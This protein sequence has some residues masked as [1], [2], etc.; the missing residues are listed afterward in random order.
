MIKNQHDVVI[1][2]GANIDS[3]WRAHHKIY[4]GSSS[5]GEKSEYFG[6]VARNIAEALAR[7]GILCR[8]VSRVGNDEHGRA[9]VSHLQALSVDTE[10][11]SYS[12]R[13]PTAN[14]CAFFHPS[15]DVHTALVDLRIYDECCDEYFRACIPQCGTSKVAVLDTD[16]PKTALSF[17]A[18]SLSQEL[19]VSV[20]CVPAVVKLIPM[21]HHIDVLFLN[22]RELSLLCP[23]E[24][25]FCDQ[26]AWLHK[27][28]VGV[29]VVTK[30]EEGA[31]LLQHGKH[32]HVPAI[33][34][35]VIDVTGAGDA[36]MA[37]CLA[38]YLHGLPLA[39]SLA[40]GMKA[41]SLTLETKYSVSPCLDQIQRIA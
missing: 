37:G 8:L 23:T 39:D 33:P 21:L 15:G 24:L 9:M 17:L 36:L 31:H 3:K 28:G 2:G 25:A 20:T 41:A 32:V 34:T 6:G 14:Y 40:I 18:S 30:G 11:V 16:L 38:G 4:E 1:F 22:H 19:W 35:T 27:Q 7:M 29:L 13:F 5:S 12:E 10:F 26:I